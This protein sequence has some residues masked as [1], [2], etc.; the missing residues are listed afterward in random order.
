MPHGLSTISCPM[1]IEY[2]NLCTLYLSDVLC[3]LGDAEFVSATYRL[4]KVPQENKTRGSKVTYK[5]IRYKFLMELNVASFA[6]LP[7]F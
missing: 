3:N 2:F 7:V 4:F 6:F 5:G 1:R